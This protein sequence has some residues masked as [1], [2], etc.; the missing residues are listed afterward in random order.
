VTGLSAP[1][2]AMCF[3]VQYYELLRL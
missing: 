1:S 2:A 3:T